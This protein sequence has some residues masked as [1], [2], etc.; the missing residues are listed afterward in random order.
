MKNLLFATAVLASLS[1]AATARVTGSGTFG[2]TVNGGGSSA[3]RSETGSSGT[4]T[5]QLGG[6]AE[7]SGNG[8]ATSFAT[9]TMQNT[10]HQQNLGAY[11]TGNAF[12]TGTG[13]SFGL[14]HGTG[15][16]G[17]TGT[18]SGPFAFNFQ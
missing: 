6:L 11:T 12:A 4:V 18:G 3:G 10:T 2:A 15:T 14:A 1:T 5:S 9:P 17:F 13:Q 16:F 7:F 8:L